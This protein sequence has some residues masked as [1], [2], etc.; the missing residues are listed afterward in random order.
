MSSV[1]V[2]MS[3][4]NGE[5]FICEQ[6]DSILAQKDVE[7]SLYIRDD[8]SSDSTKD[9]LDTYVKERGI[10]VYYCDN[11]GVGNSFMELMYT[12]PS[13]YDYYAFADQDDIW[14]EDKLIEAVKLLQESGKAL[15]G[16][17]QECVDIDG[18]SMGLRYAEEKYIYLEPA[19]ILSKNM[20]AGCTMVLTSALRELMVDDSRR[21]SKTLLR[22][23][24]HDVWVAAV[25]SLCGGIAYDNRSFIKYRQHGNNVVGAYDG[26]LKKKCKERMKKAF[27]KEYR[28]GRSMLAKELLIK[29]PE[30]TSDCPLVKACASGKLAVLRNRKVLRSYTGESRLGFFMK[31]VLG[32]F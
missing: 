3:A 12:A 30:F 10:T 7:V 29:F 1:A 26:G 25:G 22:N 14:E 18:N 24:I 32:L 4:Y 28:N 19:Q 5:K 23:R 27:H 8:G 2:L 31:V 17:N 13:G 15:Y 16:S 6:I 9:I 20:I 21:P 11:V